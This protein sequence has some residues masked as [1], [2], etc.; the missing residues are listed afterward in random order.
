MHPYTEQLSSAAD[1]YDLLDRVI[2]KLEEETGTDYNQVFLLA[3]SANSK[4]LVAVADAISVHKQR[5]RVAALSGLLGLVV[6]SGDTL[7]VRNTREHPGYFQ[8]VVETTSELVVPIVSNNVVLGVMNSES[9][10][11]GHYTEDICKKVEF[12][13]AAFAELLDSFGWSPEA[14]LEETPWIQREPGLGG[15]K[16]FE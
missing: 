1:L 9:E 13:T 4:Q 12:L 5:Y 6:A 3:T 11:I 15:S 2:V 8:A 14:G 10:T 7:N 16:R